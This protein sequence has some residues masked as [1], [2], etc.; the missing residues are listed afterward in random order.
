MPSPT[1]PSPQSPQPRENSVMFAL[2]ELARLE[3][4][5]LA[6][7]QARAQAQQEETRRAR[8]REESERAEASR[9][10]EAQAQKQRAIAEAEAR[11]RVEAEIAQD[12]RMLALQ[13]ELA[14]VQAERERMHQRVVASA[15]SDR[16][17][18]PSSTRLWPIAFGLASVVAA[19]LA[20][21]L[22]VQAQRAPRVVEVERQVVVTVPAVA[23]PSSA[24]VDEAPALVAPSVAVTPAPEASPPRRTVRGSRTQRTSP[25]VGA[26]HDDGLDF[27]DE[28]DVIG[29]IEH[30]DMQGAR[31]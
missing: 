24:E 27:G 13:S 4:D 18:R 28:D 29:G 20:A 10:A 21:L 7:E 8:E 23:A 11:L 1:S 14:R 3:T 15:S 26:T 2:G 9:R 5:R 16:E 22:V 12:A 19:G 6:E 17:A 25:P 30:V 31:R